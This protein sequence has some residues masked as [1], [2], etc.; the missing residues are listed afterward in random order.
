MLS[1][2]NGEE[3]IYLNSDISCQLDEDQE[4]QVE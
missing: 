4:D 3:I 2:I 1:L